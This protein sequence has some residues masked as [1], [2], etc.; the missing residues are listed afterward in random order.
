MAKNINGTQINQSVTIV[1]KAGKAI[2]I[3]W[4]RHSPWCG[5]HRGWLQRCVRC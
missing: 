2:V 1:E 3:G 4:Y 5:H